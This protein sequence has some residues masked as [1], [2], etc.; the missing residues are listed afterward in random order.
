MIQISTYV[1]DDRARLDITGRF[2]FNGRK[3]IREAYDPLL[4]D[5]GVRSIE[6]GLDKVEYIDSSALGILLLLR[7]RAAEAGKKIVLCRATGTVQ[8]VLAVANFERLFEIRS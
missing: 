5:K 3:A 2:D 6:I 8:K 1:H 7:D 4:D